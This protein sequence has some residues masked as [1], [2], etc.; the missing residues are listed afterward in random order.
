MTQSTAKVIFDYWDAMNSNDWQSV[1]DIYLAADFICL[2][3]QSSE[4]LSGRDDFVRVNSA[5]PGQGGWRF[6]II[7][8][9]ADAAKAASDVRV[10]NCDLAITVR[11]I[12]FHEIVDGQIAK[13]TEF[14]PDPYLVPDWRKGML[15]VDPDMAQF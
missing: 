8:V 15:A 4:V 7:S 1:A 9:T 12:T 6:E 3:P 14:W 13:Q 5:F 11:V 10:T 2:W